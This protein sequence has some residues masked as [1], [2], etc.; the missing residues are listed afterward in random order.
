M[1][2]PNRKSSTGMSNGNRSP[3]ACAL[4]V[5]DDRR[6]ELGEPTVDEYLE[7]EHDHHRDPIGRAPEE[8]GV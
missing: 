2:Q 7:P 1:A 4:V 5:D 8:S 6:T 3:L